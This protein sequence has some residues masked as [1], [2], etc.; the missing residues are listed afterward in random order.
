MSSSRLQKADEDDR[1]YAIV[2]N[3]IV[4][5]QYFFLLNLYYLKKFATKIEVK[6]C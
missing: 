4:I 1:K 6:I 3:C 5:I 2:T